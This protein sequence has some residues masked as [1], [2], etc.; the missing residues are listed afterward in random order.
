[1]PTAKTTQFKFT[2]LLVLPI[3]TVSGVVLRASCLHDSELPLRMYIV[4]L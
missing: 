2:L 3:M 4:F 1:M